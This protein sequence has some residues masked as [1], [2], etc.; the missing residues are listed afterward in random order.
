M[1]TNWTKAQRDA[2]EARGG[3]VLVSAAAGSGKT[4]VLVQRVI[5]RITDKEHPT[6]V[7]RLLV[8]TFTKAAA[9]EMRE[10]ISKRLV[11][12]IESDPANSYLKRQKMLLAGADICTMDSFCSRLIKDNFEDLDI[13]PDFS[14]L[15]DSEHKMLM[16]EAVT[17]ILD[18]IYLE[19]RE[20]FAALLELFTNGKSDEN[21]IKAIFDMYDFSMAAPYPD[22]WLMN[23][24]KHYF[25]NLPIEQSVWGSFALERLRKILKYISV[26]IDKILL[27]AP[28]EGKLREAIDS[29]LT[30]ISQSIREIIDMTYSGK[31]DDIKTAVDGLK[32]EKFQSFSKDE[33]DDLYFEIKDRR[34]L[35][36]KDIEKAQQLMS[37]YSA[38]F[39]SDMEYLRPIMSALRE[40]STRFSEKLLELKRERNAYY[41]SDILHMTLSLLVRRNDEGNAEKTPLAM[42]LSESYDEILIDEFQDTNEAQ[43]FLFDAISKNSENKFMVGDVKQSIYRFRQAMPEI[44]ISFKDRF[45]DYDSGDYPAQISLDR[46]FRSRRGV[47]DAVN[48]FFDILMSRELG[49]IDYKNGEQLVFAADYEEHSHADTEVHIVEAPDPKASNLKNESRYIGKLIKDLVNSKMTVGKKG[50]ERPV[51][52]GD[53]C[54]LMRAV[55]S[56]A[57]TVVRELAK[58][59]IP[60]HFKKDGGFFDNAEVITVLSMLK[61]IDNPVQD[62]PLVS[63]MLSPMFPF[64]EDDLARLRCNDRTGSIYNIL[65]N[66]YESDANIK[67]FLDTVSSLR[68]LSVTLGIGELIRRIFEI[69]AY[70]SVVGAMQNGEKRALNLRMLINYAEGYEQNGGH[71]LSGFIRYVDKLRKNDYDFEDANIVSE[72]DDVVRIMTIHKSKGLEFPV[73]IVANCGGRF[74]QE[75]DIK[76]LADKDLGVGALRYDSEL[77]KEYATQTFT[78][79]K[80]KNEL[81]ELSESLRVLYVAMTRARER[82]ILV[83]SMYKPEN[84]IKELYSR[85]YTG[86]DDRSV[87]LSFCS[88]FMQWITV[89]MLY[90]PRLKDFAKNNGISSLRT[91]DNVCDID[92]IITRSPDET[93]IEEK[94]EEAAQADDR[95]IK[96]IDE[97]VSYTYPY[98]FLAQ[99]AVKYTASAMDREQKNDFVA[100]E[101]PAFMG[102]SELTPAQRGTLNHRFMEKCD[103]EKAAESVNAELERLKDEGV[104][105]PEEAD[106]V[107]RKR[108]ADFLKSKLFRRIQAADS[109]LREQKFTMSVPLSFV[110]D[111]VPKDFS[112][113]TAVVQGV[114][115]GLIINGD[116]G[117]IV[118]YKTDCVKDESELAEKYCRQMMI[119]KT[120]AE[121]C[122]GLTDV[123]VTLY[124]FSLSKEI[125]VKF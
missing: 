72:N 31:W 9:A 25:D 67:Y 117:E 58:M 124:S 57:P 6:S 88:S 37:C 68:T 87:P 113:E 123:S 70:D 119:Y 111:D 84:K 52:Y 112:D 22:L 110:N 29:D 95:L 36:K 39:L 103:F 27:D 51:R 46:N 120:A 1:G 3:T 100:S 80:I 71:G 40:C 19:G 48:F 76:A 122:F 54:I 11:E 75:N 20:D 47:T 116:R 109:F 97:K 77:H 50:E 30:E 79:T 92:F 61:V 69:T 66:N 23:N 4:A 125:S 104:F 18:E 55:K 91:V 16:R 63:V 96:I 98:D 17:Q 28:D 107:D 14:M 121:Q 105:T 90:H 85:Y 99:T 12:M 56:Q 21:L 26:K 64:T 83:G 45:N 32:F 7:D 60:V 41:Y 43:N 49:D 65:K 86:R 62:V 15:T 118:D 38:D 94:T 93:V 34:D 53:I 24:F 114:I 73:V 78:S 89:A 101:N 8:V 74:N 106:A 2:I 82:L 44:F 81:E 35:L 10:R 5:E 115:D 42:E 33:K 13:L 102:Q 59:G 108:V